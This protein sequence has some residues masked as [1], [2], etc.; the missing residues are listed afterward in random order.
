MDPISPLTFLVLF[1]QLSLSFSASWKQTGWA[2]VSLQRRNHYPHYLDKPV[3]YRDRLFRASGPA[4]S[5]RKQGP[6]NGRVVVRCWP[7]T[8]RKQSR[9]SFGCCSLEVWA[10]LRQPR[11][12]KVWMGGF[13]TNLDRQTWAPELLTRIANLQNRHFT[14]EKT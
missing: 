7:G 4:L 3:R 9:L 1:L 12:E 6:P 8:S 14:D 11:T 13:E 5:E 10:F 2:L